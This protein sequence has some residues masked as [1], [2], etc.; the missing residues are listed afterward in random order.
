MKLFVAL[1]FMLMITACVQK[2]HSYTVIYTLNLSAQPG[3]QQVGIRGKDS[4]LSWQKDSLMNPVF[5]DSIYSV[6]ITY[7]TGYKFTEYK[8]TV[9]GAFEKNFQ[10]NRRVYFKGDTTRVNAVYDKE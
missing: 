9:N 2:T 10:N 6:T 8:F 5:K 1:F 7:I 3:I 4:P